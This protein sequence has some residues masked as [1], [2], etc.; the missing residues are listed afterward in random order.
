MQALVSLEAHEQVV[1]SLVFSPDNQILVSS[2]VDGLIKLWSVPLCQHL[3]TFKGHRRSVNGLAISPDGHLL[4]S[5][6]SDSTVRLWSFPDGKLI[7]TLRDRKKPVVDVEFSGDGR[8]VA[9]ACYGGR[10]PVWDVDGHPVQVIVAGRQ[11]LA[12]VALSADGHLVA[13]SGL[14]GDITVW[15]LPSGHLVATLSTLAVTAGWLRF[16]DGGRVLVSLGFQQ[17]VITWDTAKWQRAHTY[18]MERWDVHNLAVSPDE[19]LLGLGMQGMLQLR[20]TI[21][22]ELQSELRMSATLVSATAFSPDGRWLAAGT[23]DGALRVWRMRR[24]G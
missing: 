5:C 21:D 8:L 15:S 18:A 20:S 10:T 9:A 14:G 23:D 4:A 6:S 1:L 7:H 17:D 12:S 24:W 16:I 2:G 13:T 22:M 19:A 11:N 3:G